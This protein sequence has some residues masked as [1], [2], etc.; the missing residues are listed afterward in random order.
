M[1]ILISL[2]SRNR[3]ELLQKSLNALHNFQSDENEIIY[4]VGAEKNDI[5]TLDVVEKLSWVKLYVEQNQIKSPG[6]MWNRC[7]NIER[8][9]CYIAY[10]DDVICITK[11]WDKYIAQYINQGGLVS[12][13]ACTFDTEP[14]NPIVSERWFNVVGYLYPEHFPFWFCDTW[15]KELYMFSTGDYVF[16]NQKIILDGEKGKTQNMRELDWWWGFFNATR[17][18][19][20]KEA[21]NIRMKLKLDTCDF[22]KFLCKRSK[23][24]DFCN[25]RDRKERKNIPMLEL[26]L[27]NNDKPYN[28]YYEIKQ[29]AINLLK[30][31]NLEIW[32][33]I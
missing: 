32:K 9:D 5:K 8:A 2:P 22:E 29:E 26:R 6:Q 16:I 10:T 24:I 18:L 1:K 27:S 4:A 30:K 25:K 11:D 12:A 23:I 7:A 20:L 21:Y 28:N 3:P 14:S 13:F 31:E 15:I 33:N 19:R 17:K